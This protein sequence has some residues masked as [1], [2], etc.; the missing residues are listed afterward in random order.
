M[1][2]L[3][4]YYTRTGVTKKVAENMASKL[5][6][7]VEEIVDLEDRSGALGYLAAG[8][9]ATL[10]KLTRIKPIEQKP[11]KYDIIILGTPVWAWTTTPAIRSYI[12]QNR[13]FLFNKKFA[14]FCTMGG[15][16]DVGT[17]EAMEELLGV[18]PIE[19]LALL[20]TDVMKKTPKYDTAIEE[21]VAAIKKIP[22]HYPKE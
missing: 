11:S 16:G 20:T 10:K 6:A 15:N 3:I 13:P 21:F 22:K 7:D 17:F 1:K 12:T 9:D 19:T 8:R 2:I 4:A 18:E 5:G 14:F